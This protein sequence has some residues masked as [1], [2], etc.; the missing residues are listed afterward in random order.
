M[1]KMLLNHA[2]TSEIQ[3]QAVRDGMLT[4]QEDGYLKALTGVTTV[5]EVARVA[6]DY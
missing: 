2:T 3:D 6:T 4:M 5:E 1:E